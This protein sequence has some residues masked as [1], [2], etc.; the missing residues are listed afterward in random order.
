MSVK[1]FFFLL[2]LEKASCRHQAH[3]TSSLGKTELSSGDL[4]G[5]SPLLFPTPLQTLCF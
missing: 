2:T 5:R 3:V 4:L 1:G